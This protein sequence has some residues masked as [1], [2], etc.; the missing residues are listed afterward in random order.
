MKAPGSFWQTQDFPYQAMEW[1]DTTSLYSVEANGRLSVSPRVTLLAGLRQ[2]ADETGALLILD[3]V[4]CGVART[5]K[6]FAHEHYDLTPD[7]LAFAKGIGGGFPVG[8]IAGK[9]AYMD[10]LD[11]GMWQY[12]DESY[13]E[14]GVTFFAG[15][16]VRHPLALAAARAVLKRLKQEGPALQRSLSDKTAELARTLNGCFEE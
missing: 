13:P 9:R 5:G 3:E 11:G 14:V 1:N 2:L 7:I 15:T 4:Q 6:L 8:V 10:A 16:F 12:G